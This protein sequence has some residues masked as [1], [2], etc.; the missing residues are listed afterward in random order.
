MTAGQ[1]ALPGAGDDLDGV[2]LLAGALHIRALLRVHP[3][4]PPERVEDRHHARAVPQAAVAGGAHGDLAPAVAVEAAG[5]QCR[6]ERVAALRPVPDAVRALM[7]DIGLLQPPVPFGV[8]GD[9]ARA[10]LP[11]HGRV[12]RGHGQ[13]RGTGPCGDR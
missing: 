1:P 7:E 9:R 8:Q 12:R 2:P 5:G 13:E 4:V 3:G 6:A 11:P 10:R